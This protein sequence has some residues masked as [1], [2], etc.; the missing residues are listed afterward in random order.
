MKIKRRKNRMTN[1]EKIKEQ[2]TVRDMA[3]Q[4]VVDNPCCGCP[5]NGKIC[6]G[7]SMDCV[8]TVIKWLEMEAE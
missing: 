5:A 6:D 3:I 2:I 4:I 7:D 8:T 1:F